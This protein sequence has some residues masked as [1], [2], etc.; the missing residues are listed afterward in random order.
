MPSTVIN[1]SSIHL[2]EDKVNLL[3]KGLSFCPTPLQADKEKFLDDLE[4]C[5][6]RL[7]LKEFFVDNEGKSDDDDVQPRFR[8]PSMWMPPKCGDASLK[9]YIRKFRADIQQQLEGDVQQQ[10]EA[11]QLKRC[12]DNLTS[13]ERIALSK[14][15]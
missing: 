15:R 7:H 4:G 6:R 5:F 3:S 11:N 2:S 8:P 9:I 1:L 14:L 13:N 12:I 10:L